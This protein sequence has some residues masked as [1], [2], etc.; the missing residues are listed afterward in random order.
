MKNI[1]IC[2]T[3]AIS[4]LTAYGQPSTNQPKNAVKFDT[5]I[6]HVND[7]NNR[8]PFRDS[9]ELPVIFK[10]KNYQIEISDNPIFFDIKEIMLQNPYGDNFPISLSVIYQNH[11]IS[12]FDS[13]NFVCHAIPDMNRDMA[14]EKTLNTKRFQYHWLIGDKLVGYSEGKYYYF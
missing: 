1:I 13:G 10:D 5:I 11:I 6:K 12:L 3:F 2:F 8:L 14:L 7:F 9:I 4:A